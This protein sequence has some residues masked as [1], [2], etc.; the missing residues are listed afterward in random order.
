[1]QEYSSHLFFVPGDYL[2]SCLET[3][4]TGSKRQRHTGTKFMGLCT[5]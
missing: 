4:Y 2:N 5:A 3:N 1:M